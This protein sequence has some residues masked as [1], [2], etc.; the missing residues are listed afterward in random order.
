MARKRVDNRGGARSKI[1]RLKKNIQAVRIESYFVFSHLKV[2]RMLYFISRLSFVLSLLFFS[3]SAFST[4]VLCILIKT[5]DSVTRITATNRGEFQVTRSQSGK[6]MRK[7][8]LDPLLS[9][10]IIQIIEQHR[11][12]LLRDGQSV[13]KTVVIPEALSLEE[14]LEEYLNR[15]NLNQ[16]PV[17]VLSAQDKNH[18][19]LSPPVS[20][21]HFFSRSRPSSPATYERHK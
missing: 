7:V 13:K 11:I 21:V 4:E 2:T 20:P 12:H 15:L 17:D 16:S 8:L 18:R 10:K 19:L 5:S 9:V 6:K 3:F 1:I 14:V